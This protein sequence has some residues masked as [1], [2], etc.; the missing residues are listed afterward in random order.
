[1]NYNKFSKTS[2]Y[3]FISPKISKSIFVEEQE[4][5]GDLTI[6]YMTTAAVFSN[7]CKKP[8]LLFFLKLHIFQILQLYRKWQVITYGSRLLLD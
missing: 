6:I 8:N 4:E 1:M 7:W 3:I 5:E 2:M